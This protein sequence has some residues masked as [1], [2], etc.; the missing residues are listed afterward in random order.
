LN[1]AETFYDMNGYE[2][3]YGDDVRRILKRFATDQASVELEAVVDYCHEH[4]H[5]A[6]E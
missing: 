3:D 4:S 2:L 1:T 6:E 5:R